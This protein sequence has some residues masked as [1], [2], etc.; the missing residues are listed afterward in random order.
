MAI[1]IELSPGAAI[2]APGRAF[3]RFGISH[4]SMRHAFSNAGVALIFFTALMPHAGGFRDSPANWI[5]IA[6][7]LLMGLLSLVRIAPTA[8]A[9][10]TRS[11]LAT[12]AM[13]LAPLLL[14][15]DSGRS[16]GPLAFAA[17]L[18]ELIGVVTTQSARLYLGRRFALLPANRGI[19]RRGPFRLIRHPIYFGW[20][21]LSVGYVMAY[22]N[23]RNALAVGITIPFMIWRIELEEELLWQDATYRA[24]CAVTP[25]RLLPFIF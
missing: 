23:A 6:G 17:V 8:T 15:N 14:M 9:I 25:Y 10:N 16:T 4:T 11:I 5:W 20:L 22:P 24:Y 2:T 7:A 21:I 13:M 18:V 3:G 19:E 1:P 12:V